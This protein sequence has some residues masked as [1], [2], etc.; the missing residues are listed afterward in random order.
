MTT[1]AVGPS[2]LDIA[3]VIQQTFA[4]LKRNLFTFGIL[5]F[6]LCGLPAGLSAAVQANIARDAVAAASSGVWSFSPGAITGGSLSGLVALVTTAILQGAL[7]FATVRDL[8]GEPTS[9]GDSLATGL[10]NFLSLIIVSIAVGIC[11]VFGLILLVVPGVM[12]ACAWCVALP[13]LVADRTGIGGAF[14]RSADLTRGHRWQIFGL[15]VIY[16]IA[17]W[18]IGAIFNAISGMGAI[19]YTGGDPAAV[20]DRTFSPLF[21]VFTVISSTVTTVIGATA[22]A[23]TYVELRRLRE[24][25]GAEW[26]RDIFS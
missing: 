22:I 11:V 15:F 3:R 4:V 10:R 1:E 20:L 2:S 25:G 19:G 9:V 21:I 26:L 8:N 12:I 24:G 13:A 16:V 7:I 14:G 5:G 18:I 17:S 23:V 6:L